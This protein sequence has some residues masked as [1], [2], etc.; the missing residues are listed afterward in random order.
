MSGREEHCLLLWVFVT[1]SCSSRVVVSSSSSAGMVWE[2]GKQAG[3]ACR[4]YSPACAVKTWKAL[5][6]PLPEISVP[7]WI[8]LCSQD[9]QP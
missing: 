3:P 1:S 7:S 5:K 2:A 4:K 8:S 9:P 6:N